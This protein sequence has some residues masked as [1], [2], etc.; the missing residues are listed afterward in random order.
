MEAI[1]TIIENNPELKESNDWTENRSAGGYQFSKYLREKLKEL[2][3]RANGDG[4][5]VVR[6]LDLLEFGVDGI[7]ESDMKVIYAKRINELSKG[8]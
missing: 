2:T 4:A 1:K 7:T 3:A 6:W 8:R 5:R